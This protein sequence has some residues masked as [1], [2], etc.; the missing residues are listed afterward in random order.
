MSD[1]HQITIHRARLNYL[2][3]VA[4]SA[5]AMAKEWDETNRISL[6]TR[7]RF[8]LDLSVL[9]ETDDDDWEGWDI[10]QMQA[11][12]GDPVHLLG[13]MMNRMKR[14]EQSRRMKRAMHPVLRKVGNQDQHRNLHN[15]WQRAHDV[16]H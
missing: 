16:A 8:T 10:E 12:A 6:E 1:D 7:N 9:W 15:Q 3:R 4:E 14:P 11:R 5:H 13:G 2:E